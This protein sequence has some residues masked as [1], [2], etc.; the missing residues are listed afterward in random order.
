[1]VIYLINLDRHTKRLQYMQN[2][3]QGLSV[4]RIRAVEGKGME[5]P[6]TRHGRIQKTYETLDKYNRACILSHRQAWTNFLETN[7]SFACVLEDDLFISPDFPRFIKDES[8]IPSDCGIIKIETSFQKVYLER[9]ALSCLGRTV[10]LL[11]STHLG[12]AAYI[13]SRQGAQILLETTV[14]PAQPSDYIMFGSETLRKALSIHQLCPA[15]CT[16]AKNIKNGILFPDLES[17]IQISKKRPQKPLLEKLTRETLRPFIHFSQFL[18]SFGS[19]RR[20]EERRCVVKF[21]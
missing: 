8:W 14:R 18:W 2:L 9:R 3:L 17:A 1:M 6:E 16:Q 13:I 12:S 4:Q 10:T 7:A 20:I 11:K 5:G 21:R 19:G 15:L